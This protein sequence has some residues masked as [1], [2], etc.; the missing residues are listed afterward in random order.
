MIIDG[1][2][3]SWLNDDTAQRD[4]AARAEELARTY[5]ERS[6]LAALAATLE[7]AARDGP[8]ALLDSA[9][10][11]LSSSEAA[12]AAMEPMIEAA[13]RDPFYRPHLRLSVS[14]VHAGLLL[15]DGPAAS[16]VLGVLQA[17][18]IAAKRAERRDGA[19]IV[20][21]GLRSV[22]RFI[23][24]G[25]ATLSFWEAP[26]IGAGFTAR[27]S[28]RCRFVGRRRIADGETIELD[29]SRETFVV[30]AASRDILYLQATPAAAAAPLTV[31]YDSSTRRF[32]GACSTDEAGSR[33]QLMLALLRLMDRRDAVPLFEEMLA[34]GPFHARWQAMRELL[35]LE[36]EAAFPHLERMASADPHPE[37]RKAAAQTLA[38]FFPA[39][40]AANEEARLC[41]A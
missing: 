38:R 21:T 5:S 39:P 20:F 26:T 36:A 15:L 37:V 8:R 23:R 11:Y 13:L 19:S 22:C 7:A 16:L 34:R 29:G 9:A 1:A 2:L 18:A 32:V 27:H 35:A 6:G 10:P 40:D 17:D 3:Q 31:E 24:A 41:H 14:E 33:T 12:A 28:G 25:S 4:T 30:E